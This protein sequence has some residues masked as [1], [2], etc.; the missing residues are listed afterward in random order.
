[1]SDDEGGGGEEAHEEGSDSDG[2]AGEESIGTATLA[3]MAGDGD[4]D[5][6]DEKAPPPKE[7]WIQKIKSMIKG[8]AIPATTYGPPYLTG[9]PQ[10]EKTLI[11]ECDMMEPS[12]KDVHAILNEGV[13][14]NVIDLDSYSDTAMIKLARHCFTP[15]SVKILVILNSTM[16]ES[17]L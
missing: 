14:P 7:N 8:T 13:E 3:G 11:D 10:I 5:S 17:Q 16:K 12:V 1:M 15:E 6:D 4:D 9:M 2:E